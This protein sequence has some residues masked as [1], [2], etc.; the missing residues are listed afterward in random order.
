MNSFLIPFNPTSIVSLSTFEMLQYHINIVPNNGYDITDLAVLL[1]M[2]LYRSGYFCIVNING[3]NICGIIVNNTI[4]SVD[5]NI[6]ISI[7]NIFLG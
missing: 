6:I 7:L 4:H 2:I 5:P 3:G 1:G